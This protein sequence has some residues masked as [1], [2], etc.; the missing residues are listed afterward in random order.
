MTPDAQA[1]PGHRW[2]HTIKVLNF[3]TPENFA[4]ISLKF[5]LRS[6]TEKIVHKVQM[7]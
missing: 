2:A 1:D 5:K 3:W 7:E 4:V 6:L